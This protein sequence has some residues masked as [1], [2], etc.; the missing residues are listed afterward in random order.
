M[1][2]RH[3][4][5]AHLLG[6]T[7]LLAGVLFSSAVQAQT[8]VGPA[9][10]NQIG[11]RVATPSIVQ[12]S[13]DLVTVQGPVVAEA[14]AGSDRFKL[15][16]SSVSYDG[17]SVYGANDLEPIYQDKIGQQITVADVYKIAAEITRKYRNDGY[18]LTQIV[19]PP[20]TIEDGHVRL[21]VVEGVVSAITV[22]GVDNA[23][24]R[25]FIESYAEQVKGSPLNTKALEQAILL[26]NDLPGISARAII[27]PS[28]TESGAADLRIV[29]QRKSYDGLLSL[30]NYGSRYLGPLQ[31]QASFS[32]NSWLGLNERVTAD[33][34]YAPGG[35]LSKELAYGGLTYLQPFGPYGTSV[36]LKAAVASTDPG[37]RLAQYDVNGHSSIYSVQL[38]Q[39]I[40]RT[41]MFNWSAYGVFDVR[42][43]STQ[44]NIDNTRQDYIRAL[45]AGTD[46]DFVDNL[47]SPA[48]TTLHLE[49]AQGLT[50]FGASDNGDAD[51][52][53]AAGNPQFTKVEGELQRL[54]RLTKNLN[55]LV[56]VRGQLANDAML[57]SEEFGVGGPNYGRGYDPSEVVGDNG[58]AG[59]LELQLTAPIETDLLKTYQLYTFLDAGRVWN[60]D[61]TTPSDRE[62]S[63]VSTG[64]G[65]R[66][67][68][69]TGTQTGVYVA[70][71]LN[72]DV[73]ALGNQNPRVYFN[74]QHRF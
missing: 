37:Y 8:V 7:F 73:E 67:T 24:E 53:R 32:A 26:I 38:N 54:Q 5:H 58:V 28:A 36:E 39:P 51:L 61:P 57:S 12:P 59:K 19:V 29:A 30:D 31:G 64:V 62:M 47:L 1:T 49:V 50:T 21:Q 42:N 33:F 13:D 56:G 46:A 44:S 74:L 14:P 52:S 41:R 69:N 20:Q 35:G 66:A 18:I 60:E 4:L 34:I 70:L 15:T 72:R 55:L 45:R 3:S 71:P 2:L 43:N 63:V 27:S 48:F 25:A 10:V 11:G 68:L 23:G 17:L 40:I 16:L 6:T 22:D 9:D 65:V